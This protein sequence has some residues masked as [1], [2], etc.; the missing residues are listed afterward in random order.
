MD[1]DDFDPLTFGSC[2]TNEGLNTAKQATGRRCLP[3][4]MKGEPYV[5]GPIP[6]AW[7]SRAAALPGKAF[8]L[9]MALWYASQRT[10]AKCP[11]VVLSDKLAEQF[12]LGARTTRARAL[13]SLLGE[14]LVSVE[15]REGQA[16]RVTILATDKPNP[17]DT[18]RE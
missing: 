15:R 10:K 2:L 11:T 14:G 3:R 6:L 18:K 1:L 7:V 16:P 9:G 4:P 5:G 17:P 8:H 13:A 12:G